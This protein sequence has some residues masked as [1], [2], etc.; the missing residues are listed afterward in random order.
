M[1]IAH[2]HARTID[3]DRRLACYLAAIAG[4]L[5]AAAFHAVGFF[6]AN[7]TGNVS[8]LSDHMATGEWLIG[9]FYLA[10]LLVFIAGAFTSGSRDQRRAPPRTSWRLR[11]CHPLRGRPFAGPWMCR[12]LALGEMARIHPRPRARIPNGTSKRGRYAHFG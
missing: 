9:L 6:A 12:S 10:I 1:L 8:A 7:M 11:L 4:A 5:N 3:V 2:G